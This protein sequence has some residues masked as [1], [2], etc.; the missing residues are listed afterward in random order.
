MSDPF[1]YQHI[2]NLLTVTVQQFSGKNWRETW[3]NWCLAWIFLERTGR[4]A[5]SPKQNAQTCSLDI[6]ITISH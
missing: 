4:T 5:G 1:I 3:L 2:T 6:Y